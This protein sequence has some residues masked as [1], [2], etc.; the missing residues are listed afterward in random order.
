YL[1]ALS[2]RIGRAPPVPLACTKSLFSTKFQRSIATKGDYIPHLLRV[3]RISLVFQGV[4]GAGDA[5]RRSAMFCHIAGSSEF[6][7]GVDVAIRLVPCVEQ[8]CHSQPSCACSPS[9]SY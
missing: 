3:I 5:R 8:I 4:R 7:S 9:H 1:I 6:R 2:F